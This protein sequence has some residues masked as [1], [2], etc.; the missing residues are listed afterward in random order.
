MIQLM[1]QKDIIGRLRQTEFD[2]R[3][4]GVG[5]L[6][7]FGSYSRDEAESGSD[8]DVFVDPISTENFGFLP[9]MSVYEAIRK[10]IGSDVDLGYS[11]RDG[12]NRYI[13][14][15]AEQQAIRIF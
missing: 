6:F 8:I 15:D 1:Q 14:P 2:L 5:A 13:R 11:T 4:F 7:L 3:Q 12:L 9:F 10:A